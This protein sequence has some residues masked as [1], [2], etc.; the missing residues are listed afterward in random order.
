M[1]NTI[2]KLRCCERGEAS[3]IS[4]AIAV[5]VGVMILTFALNVFGVISAKLQ[6]DQATEQMVKQ[7]QLSGG[8]NT[9]TADLFT[10]LSANL[11]GAQN[12]QYTLEAD[13]HRPTPMGMTEAIQLGTPFYL[14]V[15][16]DATLGG[17]GRI[18]PVSLT[19]RSTGAGVSE[20]FWKLG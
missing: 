4:A 20:V 17:F 7:I 11:T 14:T 3:Y 10:H 5:L 13:Y 15:T 2:K 9:D 8:V 19:L 12:A 6:L 18:L 1:H 16:A